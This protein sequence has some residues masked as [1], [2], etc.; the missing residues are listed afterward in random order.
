MGFSDD[1]YYKLVNKVELIHNNK[2]EEQL[3]ETN[4]RKN[5]IF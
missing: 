4:L 1:E 3:K 5:P 2:I